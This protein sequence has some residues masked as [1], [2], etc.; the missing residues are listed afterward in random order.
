MGIMLMYNT[1]LLY[2]DANFQNTEDGP[3][4]KIIRLKYNQ[5]LL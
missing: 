5:K 2:E 3:F 1:G 4:F